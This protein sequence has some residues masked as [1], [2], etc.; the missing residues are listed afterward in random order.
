MTGDKITRVIQNKI[1]SSSKEYVMNALEI[2]TNEKHSRK[3]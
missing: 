3:L 2:L 1:K